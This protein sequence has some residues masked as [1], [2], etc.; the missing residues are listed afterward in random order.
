MQSNIHDAAESLARLQKDFED[1]VQ[2]SFGKSIVMDFFNP[3]MSN[4][5]M[6]EEA[7]DTAA[8]EGKAITE[9]INQARAIL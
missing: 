4:V 7:I 3:C 6:I 9:M 8:R 2:D 1:N 5:K